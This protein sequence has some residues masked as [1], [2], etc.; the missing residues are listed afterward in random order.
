MKKIYLLLSTSVALFGHIAPTV[1]VAI[2]TMNIASVD[3]SEA[4]ITNKS[5][6]SN[7]PV[8]E[9]KPLVDE[10]NTSGSQ[11]DQVNTTDSSFSSEHEYTDDSYEDTKVSE[12]YEIS[13]NIT[14]EQTS[15][16]FRAIS[17]YKW[18]DISYE[19]HY[20][21]NPI[22]FGEEFYMINKVVLYADLTMKPGDVADAPWKIYKTLLNNKNSYFESSASIEVFG[23]GL[24][25]PKDSSS[26]FSDLTGDLT[27]KGNLDGAETENMSALF[28]NSSII[29]EDFKMTSPNVTNMSTMFYGTS[30]N[31]STI[32]FLENLDTKNV[33]NM[34]GM[35]RYSKLTEQGIAVISNFDMRNVSRIDSMLSQITS[36]SSIDLNK[37]DLSNLTEMSNLFSDSTNLTSVKVDQWNTSKVANYSEMFSNTRLE[38]IN[39]EK[40]DTTK[41]TTNTSNMFKGVSTLE[42]IT[43]GDNFTFSNSAGVPIPYVKANSQNGWDPDGT[44]IKEDGSTSRYAPD[45]FSVS[46]G[47]GEL[48]S[49]TYVAATSYYGTWGTANWKFNQVKNE[50]IIHDGVLGTSEEAKSLFNG[51]HGQFEKLILNGKVQLPEN[52]ANLF[53]KFSFME[54]VEGELDTSKAVDLSRL[55]YIPSDSTS[56][57]SG[58][59]LKSIDVSNWDLRKAENITEI[60]LMNKNLTNLDVKNWNTSNIKNF[61]GAF[62]GLEMLKEL[63]VSNWNVSSAENINSLFEGCSN[64]SNLNLENWNTSSI[65]SMRAVFS[66]CSSLK[67]L[68]IAKWDTSSLTTMQSIFSDMTSLKELDLTNWD[69][70]GV[71]DMYNEFSNLKLESLTLGENFHFDVWGAMN[72]SLGVPVAR[73]GIATGK[74]IKDDWSSKSYT[75]EDF[76]ISYGNTSDLTPG[77]YVAEIDPKSLN[78]WGDCPWVFIENIGELKIFGGNLGIDS[79]SPWNTGVLDVDKIQKITIVETVKTP[80]NSSYLFSSVSSGIHLKSLVEFKG[81]ENLDTSATTIMSS[82]FSGL[83]KIKELNISTFDTS[84]VTNMQTMFYGLTSLE[85]LV[86]G[87][88]NTSEVTNMSYMFMNA[89]KL[90]SLDLSSFD[91]SKVNTM[92]SMFQNVP[93][94]KLTLGRSFIFSASSSTSLNAPISSN[95]NWTRENGT[96]RGYSPGDFIK[97]YGTGDLT[98]GTY[99][100]EKDQIKLDQ[101]IFYKSVI[102]ETSSFSFDAAID[103]YPD[104]LNNGIHLQINYEEIKHL[105]ELIGEVKVQTYDKD[106]QLVDNFSIDSKLSGNNVDIKLSK[107]YLSNISNIH[108]E[109]PYVAW[110]NTTD[111][112]NKSL[113]V[114]YSS[115]GG[116]L[117]EDNAY[118]SQLLGELE[119]ANGTLHF[120]KVPSNINFSEV[121]QN[122]SG[123]TMMDNFEDF[124]IEITDFRGTN[125]QS[126]ENISAARSAWDL[127]VSSTSFKDSKGNSHASTFFMLINFK[128]NGLSALLKEGE[129]V[130][131]MSGGEVSE[132]PKNDHLFNWIGLEPTVENIRNKE[133]W[134]TFLLNPR[135]INETDLNEKYTATINYELRQAP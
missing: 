34:S 19:I 77:K 45:L 52:S 131:I 69:T 53:S 17:K 35:F 16:E 65:T 92:N 80:E 60:F 106:N 124:I 57:G 18:G 123:Y 121:D 111:V 110:N 4:S 1:S 25:L 63:D 82:M 61:S 89:S 98:P 90:N 62:S 74:W 114:S 115:R 15:D 27:L 71:G 28:Y 36:L 84:N 51:Q 125:A 37:W 67:N 64:L 21:V 113:G 91:T 54:I 127:L 119:I 42:K 49:G 70:T 12:S 105:V 68:N 66:G 6:K 101:L 88:I 9:S 46:Y 108:F 55:F 48:K 116:V 24:K 79:E 130:I 87:E 76:M 13:S 23:S 31:S 14:N 20:T 73:Y 97:F 83:S 30:I 33:V 96:S 32:E 117:S 22:G 8:M 59:K 26:L 109:I 100:G 11:E 5:T 75:P 112:E 44:W 86:L 47:S 78:L 107:D 94:E 99:V 103:L 58:S 10:N 3:S 126:K 39:L 29:F 38:S 133:G 135:Q 41:T 50:L 81:L 43:L 120:S 129:E 2:D 40:W 132:V 128:A 72:P 104:T 118:N 95:G 122:S 85:K 102:G 7:E 134:S 93:L 56:P